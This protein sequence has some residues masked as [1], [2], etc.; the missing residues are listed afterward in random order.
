MLT[1]GYIPTQNQFSQ[2]WIYKHLNLCICWFLF[3]VRHLGIGQSRTN[4]ADR[5]LNKTIILF[6]K[7]PFQGVSGSTKNIYK[8]FLSHQQTVYT[9]MSQSTHS[10]NTGQTKRGWE[11]KWR[12]RVNDSRCLGST[13]EEGRGSSGSRFVSG[14]QHVPPFPWGNLSVERRVQKK[15]RKMK[16]KSVCQLD[17]F[18][19]SSSTLVKNWIPTAERLYTVVRH[20]S[21]SCCWCQQ[22]MRPRYLASHWSL[23]PPCHYRV[24]LRLEEDDSERAKQFETVFS[25]GCKLQKNVVPQGLV[26]PL[27][28]Q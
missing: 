6:F 16:R 22:E 18:L 17:S 7:C 20:C 12:N 10:E 4:R 19:L 14:H 26:W 9:N 8:H 25:Q 13:V 1:L 24:A 27:V 21:C 28:L 23:S 3:L 2:C 15:K 5:L 11:I